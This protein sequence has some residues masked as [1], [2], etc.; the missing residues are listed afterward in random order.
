[1]QQRS[2]WFIYRL[3][4][5]DAE[6]GKYHK[7]PIDPRTRMKPAKG[8]GGLTMCTDW[9]TVSQVGA[10][11]QAAASPGERYLPGYWFTA[12]DPFWFLD[13]DG[14]LIDNAWSPLAL[15]LLA[16]F[17]NA[18]R[19]TSSSGRG[20]QVIGSG[21]VPPHSC[22][23]AA[24]GLEFY[25]AD[26]GVALALTHVSGDVTADCTA[27]VAAL[28]AKYFQRKA[29]ANDAAWTDAPVWFTWYPN[30]EAGVT[31]YMRG[32]SHFTR[33]MNGDDQ[34]PD[35]S[36]V[37]WDLFCELLRLAGGNCQAV[38]EFARDDDRLDTLRARR[39]HK[40]VDRN[41]YLPRTILK[42]FADIAADPPRDPRELIGP[43]VLPV[44]ASLTPVTPTPPAMMPAQQAEPWPEPVDVFRE[45]AAP[46]FDGT[47]LPDELAEYSRLLA[48]HNG[49]DPGIGL[50]AALAVA[51]M[52]IRDEMH[53]CVDSVTEW[54]EEARLWALIIAPP[55]AGKTPAQEP[56]IKPIE[57]IDTREYAE[58]RTAYDAWEATAKD[59]RGPP[60]AQPRVL[61]ADSTIA[62]LSDVLVDNPRGVG[63]VVDEFSS[64]FGSLDIQAGGSAGGHDRGKAL[65]LFEGGPHFIERVTRKTIRVPNWSAG[66]L[67]GSTPAQMR[68]YQKHLPDDGLIQR[69]L[70]YLAR[71]KIEG[72][73]VDPQRMTAAR[74]R[75]KQTIDRLWDLCPHAGMIQMSPEA[76]E[77]FTLW[78]SSVDRHKI[79]YRDLLPPLAGHV[80]KYGT[81]ALRIALVLHCVK[82]VNAPP[83]SG[84]LHNA[85][86]RLLDLETMQQATRFIERSSVHAK[87]MYLGLSSDSGPVGVARQVARYI[88]VH[89]APE[90]ALARRDILRHVRAY[91]GA[92]EGVQAAAMRFL[93][94]MGWVCP[95]DSGQRRATGPTRFEVNPR[96]AT[97][98]AVQAAKET[99]RRELARQLIGRA[100]TER[101]ERKVQEP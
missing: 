64:W 95:T 4:D 41:D 100:A 71:D 49:F 50:H 57:A 90:N 24:L 16:Q 74:V 1:M 62:R 73:A 84:N 85:A 37:D 63:L 47:E 38:L 39:R 20:L 59:E 60:P 21:T 14:C 81:L 67:S 52:A 44:G 43:V 88:L 36:Q 45:L 55:G 83:T 78:S 35:E 70:T 65:M 82:V 26:R 46:V 3:F 93:E 97:V 53:L 2:Q 29:A 23:N 5:R 94:D 25:T 22:K 27:A 77:F 8:S 15:E 31:D 33:M 28:V 7:S 69:F 11:L 48:Q 12:D 89:K 61:I 72:V 76:R 34:R 32:V 56:L 19:Q 101:R 99:E 75:Y 66:I 18:L 6:T 87:A 17:P 9:H 80:A 54:F 58:W 30:L 98:F 51:S 91:E 40:W 86:C 96:I 68:I 13:I 42:A 10:E 92:N 79:A